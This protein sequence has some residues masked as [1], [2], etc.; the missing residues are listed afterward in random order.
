MSCQHDRKEKR[1]G[2]RMEIAHQK[3]PSDRY[4][5]RG[6]GNARSKEEIS[7]P[8]RAPLLRDFA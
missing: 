3:H 2:A 4:R 1:G 5:Y 6:G 8:R 7:S